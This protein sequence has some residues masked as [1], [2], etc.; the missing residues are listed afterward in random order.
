MRAK[1]IFPV[2]SIFIINFTVFS[3]ERIRQNPEWKGTLEYEGGIKVVRNPVD[4]L[5]GEIHLETAEDLII[6]DENKEN[7]D[8]FQARGIQVDDEGNIYVLDRGN[9]RVQKYDKTGRYI[10]TVGGKGQGPG[11]FNNPSGIYLDSKNNLY[12]R[13]V[14]KIHI[15]NSQGCFSRSIT[16]IDMILSF[17]VNK[18]GNIL[19]EI[20]YR[21]GPETG[22]REVALIN[23]EGKKTKAIVS[24]PLKRH[25]RIEG[26]IML[27]NPY[28]PRLCFCML[29]DEFGIYGFSSEYKLYLVNPSGEI[30][31]IIKK[32]DPPELLSRK[33]KDEIINRHL[34]P[35]QQ[36]KK[37]FS[38]GEIIKAL[39]F[40]EYKP[41]F[42]LIMSDDEGRIYVKR[43]KSHLKGESFDVFSM[44]GC[45]IHKITTEIP[46]VVIKNGYFYNL[47]VMQDSG[48]NRISRFK[49]ENWDQIKKN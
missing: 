26:S 6:G 44:G 32:D 14:A 48:Y 35:N 12:I 17:G 15:F 37:K 20:L 11:E 13:D 42:N 5:Y 27:G 7:Y 19:A 8:I 49:I 1:V 41:F 39:D 10:T 4:S 3:I 36:R 30:E 24:Q 47:S 31:Y 45:F 21:T 38:R 40:P 33:E 18:E 16:F 2:L 25:Y 23:P 43:L 29:D 34:E 22:M 9:S 28:S 46:P